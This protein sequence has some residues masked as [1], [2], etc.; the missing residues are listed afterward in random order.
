MTLA[1]KAKTPG[2]TKTSSAKRFTHGVP[3]VLPMWH[4]WKALREASEIELIFQADHA[5]SIPVIRSD[6]KMAQT[7][8]KVGV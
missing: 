7:L 2:T 3:Y 1:K 6:V 4:P 5:G 8:T